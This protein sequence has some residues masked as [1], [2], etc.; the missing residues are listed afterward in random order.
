M[1]KLGASLTG[2]QT[3]Q[4]TGGRAG[5]AQV[6]AVLLFRVSPFELGLV[7]KNFN[8]LRLDFIFWYVTTDIVRAEVRPVAAVL[9][10]QCELDTIARVESQ[11]L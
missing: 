4:R 1:E 6:P 7:F 5:T 10:L 8:R 2:V 3:A 11:G 9:I